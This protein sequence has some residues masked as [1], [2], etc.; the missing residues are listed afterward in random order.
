MYKNIK[1]NESGFAAL[2]IAITLV[3][4]MSLITIGFAQVIRNESKQALNRQ[5][6]SQAYY[7]AEAGINDALRAIENGYSGQKKTCGRLTPADGPGAK[8]L[9]NNNVDTSG[10]GSNGSAQWSCLL[11]DTAPSSVEY[12]SIDTETPTIFTAEAV[13]SADG[14]TNVAVNSITV[15]WHDADATN[16]NFRPTT[17][18]T[19]NSFPIGSSWGAPGVLRLAVTPIPAAFTR[20]SLKQT[21]FTSFL[22]PNRSIPAGLVGAINYAADQTQSGQIVDGQCHKDNTATQTRYCAIKMTIPGGFPAGTKL[23]FNLRSIYSNTSVK[24]TV[25][26]GNSRLVGAQSMIDSTGRSEDVLKRIQVRIPTEESYYYPGFGLESVNGI[27]KKLSVYPGYA[28][29]CGFN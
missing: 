25:N 20:E 21:T 17:G 23:F 9:G 29:G 16:V 4:V 28:Q 10:T 1:T 7:A 19:N 27:C 6:S 11:I 12:S 24:I 13:D 15:A 26:D 22:Y 2:V 5:L 14:V 8:F 3:T 18:V